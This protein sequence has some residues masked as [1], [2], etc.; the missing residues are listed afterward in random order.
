MKY[1]ALKE[2]VA[3]LDIAGRESVT[4]KVALGQRDEGGYPG[5]K[6]SR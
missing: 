5:E 3:V 2:E 6:C 1:P 4:E